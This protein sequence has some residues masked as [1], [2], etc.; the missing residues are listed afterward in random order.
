MIYTSSEFYYPAGKSVVI[1]ANHVY[2]D[3]SQYSLDESDANQYK[4][5]ITDQSLNGQLVTI[6]LTPI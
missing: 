1:M 5:K 6:K 2:L 3:A 4:F